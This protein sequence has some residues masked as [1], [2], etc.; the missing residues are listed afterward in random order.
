[1]SSRTS[2]APGEARSGVDARPWW[3]IGA[4]AAV[5]AAIANLVVYL[6]AVGLL[7]ANARVPERLGSDTYVDLEIGQVV[8][9]SIVPALLATLLA[10]AVLRWTAAPRRWFVISA[11]V[12]LLLSYLSFL[13]LDGSTGAFVTLAVMHIVAAAAIIAVVAPRLPTT[14]R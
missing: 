6:I 10:I 7:N 13:D 3:Q 8:F 4:L 11:V 5:A 9:A 1:M 14:T 12:V 2:P